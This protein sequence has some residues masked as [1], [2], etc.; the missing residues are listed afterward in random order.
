M[1]VGLDRKGPKTAFPNM[2]AGLMESMVP[3]DVARREPLHPVAEVA[4][5]SRPEDEVEMV[6]HEA[7][8]QQPHVASFG[9]LVEKLHEVGIVAGVVE[10]FGTGISA[11]KNVVAKASGRCSGGSRHALV[12]PY[13]V[14][15][16]RQKRCAE[17]TGGRPRGGHF[18]G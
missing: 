9:F 2:P 11:V 16:I 1:L 18:A 15:Q 13:Q 14:F 17:A 5:F 6:G 3:A 10:N 4:V 12:T 8:G 7:I